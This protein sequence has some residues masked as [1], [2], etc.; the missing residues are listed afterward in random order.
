M[1]TIFFFRFTNT[2]TLPIWSGAFPPLPRSLLDCSM[3]PGTP[4]RPWPL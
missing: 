2:K 3:N 1:N 4:A